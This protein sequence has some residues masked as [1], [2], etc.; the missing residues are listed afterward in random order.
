[1]V[2]ASIPDVRPEYFQ[3]CSGFTL[4]AAAV[5]QAISAP[6]A[7]ARR[8]CTSLLLPLPPPPLVLLPARQQ[9]L[10]DPP[11]CS[12]PGLLWS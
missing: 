5:D 9:H 1:M 4:S 2:T 11:A 8:A 3:T 7:R 12:D 6:A 10:T